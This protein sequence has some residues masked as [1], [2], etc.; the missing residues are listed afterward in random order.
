M[1]YNL[2]KLTGF[3]L[4]GGLNWFESWIDDWILWLPTTKGFFSPENVKKVHSYGIE[5]N[6][7]LGFA[8]SKNLFLDM[9]GSYSWTPSINDG[10]P[11]S[12]AD[13]SVGKQLPYIPEHSSSITGRLTWRQWAFQYKWCYYSRR[14]TMSSGDVT[15]SGRL[16]VYYMNNVSLERKLMFKKLDLNLKLAVNNL[17]NEDYVSILSHPMPGINFEFFVGI[18]PKF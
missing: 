1:S 8:F 7:A 4:S 13:K 6:L 3:K 11:T 2:S 9:N 5:T 10:E 14:Y 12:P 16:P 15:L 17:F 18:L